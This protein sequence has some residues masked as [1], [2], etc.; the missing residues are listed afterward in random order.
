MAE[1]RVIAVANQKGG[2]G[3]TTTAVNTAA[4]LAAAEKRVLLVDADP[5]GNSTSGVGISQEMV[6]NS[7]YKLFTGECRMD[8]LAIDTCL[9]HLKL[10]PS[11]TELFG[12][13]VE[14]V[15]REGREMI[16]RDALVPLLADF[17]YIII[18]CPPAL[19]LL[20]INA[21]SAAKTVLIPVQCEYYALEGLS[22]LMKTLELVKDALNPALDVEGV[23]LTMYDGRVKLSREV[24]EEV[25]KHFG[26]KVYETMIPRNVSLSEA[27]SFGKPIITYDIRSKGAQSYLSLA[28]EVIQHGC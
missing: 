27:P 8:E 21:L 17:D 16:L 2:V 14:L 11:S 1:A 18:D 22:Q 15:G 9:P 24:V 25:R 13:E 19:S 4:S 5:Q 26:D 12:A 6:E 20:T 3:K 23:L 7:I 28:R 10:V